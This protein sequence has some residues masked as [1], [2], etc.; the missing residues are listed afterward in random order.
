MYGIRVDRKDPGIAP[1]GVTELRKLD[2]PVHALRH[3]ER[4]KWLFTETHG[5]ANE[6]ARWRAEEVPE[7]RA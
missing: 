2:E 5:T 7:K 3:E 4:G 6:R 1:I